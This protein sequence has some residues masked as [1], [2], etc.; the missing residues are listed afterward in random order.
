MNEEFPVGWTKTLAELMAECKEQRRSIGPSETDWTRA[1]ER[2]LLCKWVQFPMDGDIYEALD[3]TP[4]NF[5]THWAAPFTG[6]GSGILPKGTQ[7]R[8]EVFSIEPEPIAVCAQPL[9][10]EAIEARLVEV[11]D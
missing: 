4:V 10:R 9:E 1:Y 5:L 11:S 3:E 2:S 7:V 8:V 6:G